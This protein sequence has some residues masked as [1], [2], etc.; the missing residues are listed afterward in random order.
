MSK[1]GQLEATR[2]GHVGEPRDSVGSIPVDGP[3]KTRMNVS[4]DRRWVERTSHREWTDLFLCF[5]WKAM[6]GMRERSKTLYLCASGSK[7]GR[8]GGGGCPVCAGRPTPQFEKNC[9][10]PNQTINCQADMH[11]HMYVLGGEK[12]VCS[13]HASGSC[14]SGSVQCAVCSVRRIDGK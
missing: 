9:A 3:I 2:H 13:T 11:T 8:V 4:T 7:S 10:P 14:S 1:H 12:Y 5:L 6:R